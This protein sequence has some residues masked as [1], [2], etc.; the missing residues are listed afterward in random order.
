MNRTQHHR[1]PDGAGVRA[2]DGAVLGHARL[3]IIDLSARALQPMHSVDGRYA[4]VFNGEIYNYRELRP[5]LA[6]DYPFQTESDT[7]VL[8]A[9]YV[10][11][12]EACL[13]RLNGMFS[14][15]IYDTRTRAAFVARDRFGQKPFYYA[16]RGGR[17]IFA[18]EI[19][20]LIAAGVERRPN[21]AV[22]SRYLVSASYDDASDTPF[23]GIDQLSPGECGRFDAGGDLQRRFYY[24][25]SDKVASVDLPLAEAAEKTRDILIDACR[26]HMRSDV[27]VSI[28]LSGGLD[29][30]SMTACLAAA[31]ELHGGV[32]CFSVEF[33]R[34]FSERRWIEAAA[35]HVGLVSQIENFD[36]DD[37]YDSITP[38]MWHHEGPLGGL[39]NCGLHVVIAASRSQGFKV[40]QDGSGLD[41]AF[42]GYRNHHN[43]Y[44]AD[45]LT[46]GRPDAELAVRQYAANWGVDQDTARK[47]A[48][49]ELSRAVTAIDGT[50]PTRP[51][52]LT[53]DFRGA[54][55]G[56]VPRRAGTDDRLKDSL[57]DYFEISKI[58][59]NTRMMDRL[60]MAYGLEMRLPFLDHRLVELALSMPKAHYFHNGWSKSVV[61][62]AMKGL[63]DD[64]VR[65]A[66][67][68]SIQ[69][70]QGPWLR[71][72]RMRDRIKDLIE[73]ASFAGRGIFDIAKVRHEFDEFCAGKYDNSFFVWQWL[74]IE[75]WH[76]VFIDS[77][78]VAERHPLCPELS[79]PTQQ[80]PAVA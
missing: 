80:A 43:L 42:G 33:G 62:E 11:W 22:W 31:G 20:A 64:S 61:R 63:M 53:A 26:I 19:K 6:R 72:G 10:K 41:E 77:D 3:A 28:A 27:P 70:P 29:S 37:F 69:A 79:L 9:A 18:S 32:K 36:E 13:D 47:S 73:S 4:I 34:D 14:F 5:L 59:R 50:I 12:G 78:P 15:C 74:N 60:S 56:A 2:Y 68:R 66:P 57:I 8:L 46:R 48:L 30:S 49:Q 65:L 17:L 75:E 55:N 1:G 54:F 25:L 35:G 58:P 52:L 67:K 71:R 16:V 76:R 21:L 40:I 7:E 45:L 51:D 23:A 24:R 44:L 39:M 38:M